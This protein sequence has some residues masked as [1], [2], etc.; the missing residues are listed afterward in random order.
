M[1]R[2]VVDPRGTKVKQLYR[3]K[4]G[5]TPDKVVLNT[6]RHAQVHLASYRDFKRLKDAGKIT[7]QTRFQ[8]DLAHPISVVRKYVIPEE[9][10]AYHRW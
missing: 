7:A 4:P 5:I 6:L 9:V 3:L 8:V 1:Q 2:E 10:A